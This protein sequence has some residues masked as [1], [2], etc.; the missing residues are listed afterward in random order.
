MTVTPKPMWS[1]VAALAFTIALT[2]GGWLIKLGSAEEQIRNL[3]VEVT[4]IKE[5]QKKQVSI[6]I[7]QELLKQKAIGIEDDVQELKVITRETDRKINEILR[8]LP[9]ID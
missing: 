6:I 3:R 2:S 7:S 9:R 5:V 4:E 1:A 8:R